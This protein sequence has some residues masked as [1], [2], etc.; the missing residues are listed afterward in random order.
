MADYKDYRNKSMERIGNIPTSTTTSTDDVPTSRENLVQKIFGAFQT[1]VDALEY[2]PEISSK[3]SDILELEDDKDILYGYNWKTG[4]YEFASE[5]YSYGRHQ[6]YRDYEEM[7]SLPEVNSALERYKSDSAQTFFDG[8]S[9]LEIKS[10]SEDIK[11]ILEE[12]IRELEINEKL[13]DIIKRTYLKGD[14]YCEIIPDKEMSTILDIRYINP[15]D[16][17]RKE[18]KG[19]LKNFVFKGKSVKP[20]KIIHWKIDSEKFHPYGESIFELSRNAWRQLKIMIDATILYRITHG[21]QRIGFYI[22]TANLPTHEAAK[23]VEEMKGRWKKK[24]S[25]SPFNNKIDTKANPMSML[26]E[27]WIPFSNRNNN[28]IEMIGGAESI[29]PIDDLMFFKDQMLDAVG[30]PRGYLFD[31]SMQ[32][33]GKALSNLDINFARRVADLQKYIIK[34]VR[35]LFTIYLVLKKVPEIE[36]NNFEVKLKFPSTLEEINRIEL[37]TNKF[38]MIASVKGLELFPTIYILTELVGL[39]DQEAEDIMSLYMIEKGG[40]AGGEAT[41]GDVGA[42]MGGAAPDMGGPGPGGGGGE[43]PEEGAAPEE[44]EMGDVDTGEVEQAVGDLENA[45]TIFDSRIERLLM[46]SDT[47][48]NYDN[49]KLHTKKTVIEG[50]KSKKS[51]DKLITERRQQSMKKFTERLLGEARNVFYSDQEPRKTGG[52]TKFLVEG[53][54]DGIEKYINKDDEFING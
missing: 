30:I 38:N 37:L 41:A 33:S 20:W 19:R 3:R 32:F 50:L 8:E 16:I 46:E 13:P 43:A 2:F 53:E 47:V 9:I 35:K 17:D 26:E 52:Y 44:G 27:F 7:R 29:G 14:C 49:K 54:L 1:K 15:S 51:K 36:L 4:E 10:E 11:E 6:R 25:V 31:N 21:V 34:G 39:T 23:Y 18:E 22:D 28:R 42:I 48:F 40:G 12:A 24:K 5:E 45:S